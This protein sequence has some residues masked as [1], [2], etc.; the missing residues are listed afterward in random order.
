MRS[1]VALEDEPE[2]FGPGS[3]TFIGQVYHTSVVHLA[4]RHLCT[5]DVGLGGVSSLRNRFFEDPAVH[6][7]DDEVEKHFW[8]VDP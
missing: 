1:I 6:D 8:Q 7:F 3:G 2:S 5:A 4:Q